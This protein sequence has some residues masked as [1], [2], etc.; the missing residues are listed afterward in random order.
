M[1]ISKEVAQSI[2]EEAVS[3]MNHN[4][5][6]MDEE[7][8]IIASLDASRIGDF[9]EGAVEVLRRKKEVVID[10]GQQYEGAKPGVNLPVS[11]NNQVIGVI[12]ITGAPE[13]VQQFGK[14]LQRMTEILVKEAYLDE[15]DELEAQ[16]REAFV[17]EWIQ[18]NYEDEK[19]FATRGWMFGINIHKSRIAVILEMKDFQNEW[20]ERIKNEKVGVKEEVNM[21]RYRKSL[22]RLIER[23]FPE[24]HEHILLPRDSARYILLLSV[25]DQQSQEGIKKSVVHRLDEI[26]QAL[27]HMYQQQSVAGIGDV[28]TRPGEM[29]KSIEKADRALRYGVDNGHRHYFYDDLG[30][31]SFVYDVPLAVRERFVEQKLK[32]DQFKNLDEYLGLLQVFYQHNGSITKASDALHI[33]KNTLQYRLNKFT[34]M[35]G[36]DPRSHRDSTLIQIAIAFYHSS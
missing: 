2:V 28:C 4:V 33:H 6:F 5:N 21:Q 35:T 36:L 22:V 32:P 25:N 34:D 27:L 1:L 12:G 13:E 31:E 30:I 17:Q 7:G 3:I 24:K 23:H 15:Q 29:R 18:R 10:S 8:L 9:H 20:Y 16:A 19:L 26:Q 14:L 11:L